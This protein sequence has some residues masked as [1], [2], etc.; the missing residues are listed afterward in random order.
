MCSVIVHGK[1]LTGP[2]QPYGRALQ[3]FYWLVPEKP[4]CV[5]D[6]PGNYF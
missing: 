6:V 5:F 2:L 3:H 1:Q 4:V